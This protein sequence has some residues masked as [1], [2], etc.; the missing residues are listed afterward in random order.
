ML[1]RRDFLHS[2]ALLAL[3]PSVPG[4]LA[5]TAR[6][7]TPE[8][9]RRA[10]VV[11]QLSGGNDG[12]NTVVPHADEGYARYRKNLRLPT[13]RLHKVND[14]VGLHPALGGF[15]RLL[16]SGRLA[17][18]QGVGY[19]NPSR[20][21]FKSMACWHTARVDVK[22]NGD[23]F[24]P[25]LVT[26]LG[27]LGK[28]LD[29]APVPADRSPASVF[30]G[31]DPPPA[32]RARRAVSAT[33]AHLDDLSLPAGLH[34]QRAIATEGDKEGVRAFVRRS[35]LD[36][37][38]SA[39]R[40]KEAARIK[41]SRA[42]YPAS[43]LAEHLHLVARLLKAGVGTR[44]FYV[45]QGGY[46]T[47]YTQLAIH[48][49]LLGELGGA[50]RAFL[51]DLK[52]SGL[53]ERVIVLAFSEFGRRVKENGSYG[54]DHGTAAPVFVAGP[55]VRASLVGKTPSLL[56]L[57]AGDLKMGLDFRRV[58]AT[59]LDWLGLSVRAALGGKFERLALF[60]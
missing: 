17:I 39:E 11:I 20:S 15:S 7:A 27:W 38:T 34:P 47:H 51:D 42:S 9:D 44:V 10:L 53:A 59:V 29:E 48:A 8:R 1:S 28:A 16:E 24:V 60:G 31:L 40:L 23:V 12:I 21:H 14:Q 35:L 13:D 41:D 36:A 54:T 4:F 5:R 58:Y 55:G 33:M 43:R 19:P 6:A 50:V 45:E 2:S 22:N 18:V 37:Y 57:E 52:E 56:D 3:A 32:L 49:S 46:D 25:R 30:V 26:G